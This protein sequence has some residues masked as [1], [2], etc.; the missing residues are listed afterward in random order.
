MTRMVL[1][2]VV[3]ATLVGAAAIHAAQAPTTLPSGGRPG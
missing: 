2:A 1:R 3:T